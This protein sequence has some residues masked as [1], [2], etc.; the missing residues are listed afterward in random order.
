MDVSAHILPAVAWHGRLMVLAWTILAPL[1]VLIARY[2]KVTPAQRWPQHLDNKA[3]WHAHVALQTTSLIIMCLAVVIMWRHTG[4]A[5]L[6]GSLHA[7]LGWILVLVGWLQ[8]I[9]GLLRGSKGGPRTPIDS[10]AQLPVSER[11]DH[12]DMTLR[13]VVFEWVHKLGGYLAIV[14][15]VVVTILGLG[16]VAAPTWMWCVIALWWTILLTYAFRWQ[17]AGRCLDTYQAIWG[18]DPRHP[19]N[20]RG[21][22]GWGIRRYPAQAADETRHS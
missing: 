5:R 11:G 8:L 18:P 13:R 19:G 4:S 17:R 14:L 21:V 3:W 22:I 10:G 15:G 16:R 9:A 2:F 20:L 6:D 12:Y 7:R 1:G